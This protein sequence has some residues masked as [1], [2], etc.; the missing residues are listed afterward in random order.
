[1]PNTQPQPYLA[2]PEAVAAKPRHRRRLLAFLDPLLWAYPVS[3]DGVGLGNWFDASPIQFA[4]MT[5]SSIFPAASGGGA[6]D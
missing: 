5:L 2:G 1:M 6:V 3:V 4:S